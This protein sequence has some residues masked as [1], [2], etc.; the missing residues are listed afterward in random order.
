MLIGK[1]EGTDNLTVSF[2]P[3][4]VKICASFSA[5]YILSNKITVCRPFSF[6]H[7]VYPHFGEV[8]LSENFIA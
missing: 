7:S 6:V 5:L 3:S 4:P 1:I 8:P 2:L